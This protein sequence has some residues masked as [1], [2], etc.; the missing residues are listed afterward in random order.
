[1]I[2]SQ[3]V[4][5]PLGRKPIEDFALAWRRAL[6]FDDARA[7]NM[8]TIIE[9]ILPM[10]WNDYRYEIVDDH[11]LG[12]AEATTSTTE[13]YIRIS[14]SCYNGARAK[15]LRYPF[16]LAHELGHLLLHTGKPTSLAR[17]TVKP[18]LNPEWQADTFAGAFLVPADEARKCLSVDEMSARFQISGHAAQVRANILKLPGLEKKKGY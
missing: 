2:G 18:F 16:T 13:R 17:G 10:I 3:T 12:E 1:M 7:V 9:L 5:A 15:L 4:V 8:L 14:Q 11:E 6:G